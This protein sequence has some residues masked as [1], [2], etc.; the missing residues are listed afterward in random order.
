M[1]YRVA[2]QYLAQVI[3]TSELVEYSRKEIDGGVCRGCGGD[4]CS[5]ESGLLPHLEIYI[6][7]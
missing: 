5:S 3:L 1:A 7:K 4:G 2:L 6:I